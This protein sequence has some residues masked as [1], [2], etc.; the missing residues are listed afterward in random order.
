[1]NEESSDND[2]AHSDPE[3]KEEVEG[4]WREFDEAK[5]ELDAELEKE[6]VAREAKEKEEE[7]E[8]ADRLMAEMLEDSD[9]G[10]SDWDN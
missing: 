2:A 4:L 9:E 1:M 3:C 10:E 7:E 5:T 8:E 6:K